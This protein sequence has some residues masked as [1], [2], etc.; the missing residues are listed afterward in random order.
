MNILDDIIE[1]KK[2]EVLRLK[3]KYSLYSFRE[4]EFFENNCFEFYTSV[5]R[6]NDIYLIAEIKK[7]SP[8]KGII[9]ENFNHLELIKIYLEENVDAI[10]ILTDQ[11]FFQGHI[12]FLQEAAKI[13]TVPLLRKDFIIDEFQVFESKASGADLILLIAEVLSKNQINELTHAAQE[14]GM[15]VLLELHSIQQLEKIDF[16]LNKIIGINNRNLNDFK[17]NLETTAVLSKHLP[18]DVHI[19]SESGFKNKEDFELIKKT[20][21]KAVLIGELFMSA[22]DIR[23]SIKEVKEWLAA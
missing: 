13:K 16:S 17:V 19:I 7:T 21:T 3:K 10:S 22:D 20:K 12:N 6:R 15:E 11:K 18:E 14:I 23:K 4:M 2:S 1:T 9:R 8:S 5:K